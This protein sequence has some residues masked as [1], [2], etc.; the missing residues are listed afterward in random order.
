[1]HT[2]VDAEQ[3]QRPKWAH[4]TLQY[5]WDIVGDATNTRRNRYDFEEP[6]IALTSPEPFPSRNIVLV[7]SSN[8]HYYVE[9]AG[10][11][12]WES[13]MQEEYN[14]ILEN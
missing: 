12:F 1:V 8:P 13:S 4:S 10:N 6:P 11:P 3:E 7:Q 9:A 14:S 5:A 2:D